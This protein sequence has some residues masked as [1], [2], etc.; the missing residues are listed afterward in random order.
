MLNKALEM[1]LET[2]NMGDIAYS[3][4]GMT[5]V[6]QLSGDLESALMH[7]HHAIRWYERSGA[8]IDAVL[9]LDDVA[10]IAIDGGDPQRAAWFMGAVDGVLEKHGMHRTEIVSGENQLR[11][12]QV[13]TQLGEVEWQLHHNR[14]RSMSA[15]EILA[16]VK[17]WLP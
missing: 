4:K 15:E 13:I 14:G 1:A 8:T 2:G 16:E 3:Y 7:A 10:G 12:E 11:V 17:S 6:A 5:R 9:C